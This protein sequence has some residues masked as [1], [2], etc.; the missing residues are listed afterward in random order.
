V[1][2]RSGSAQ[3]SNSFAS[4]AFVVLNRDYFQHRPAT[5]GEGM[6]LGI[7]KFWQNSDCVANDNPHECCSG[8]G[9]GNCLNGA[10]D[11]YPT[12]GDTYPNYGT[13]YFVEDVENA[14]YGYTPYGT[15]PLRDE[16]TPVTSIAAGVSGQG[17][18]LR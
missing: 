4:E 1:L 6:T 16:S 18:T 12:D 17:W 3:S 11:T 8:V 13:M 2:F 10:S 15:H 14:Y 9:T 7:S 5:I